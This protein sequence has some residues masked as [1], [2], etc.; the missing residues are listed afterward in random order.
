MMIKELLQSRQHV[1]SLYCTVGGLDNFS[2]DQPVESLIPEFCQALV[3]YISL[4]HFG[5]YQRIVDGNERRTN[6]LKKVEETYPRI[7]D[8]TDAAIEFND[9][10]Q[11]IS[12][13]A[14]TSLSSDL[15]RLGEELATRIDLE[16][17]LIET[18]SG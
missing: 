18:M 8:S 10:Y 1:W 14:L 7:S 4:G 11:A 13:T 17:Q 3:D 6:T 2:S 9:K 15:S 16:D 5:I 12:C